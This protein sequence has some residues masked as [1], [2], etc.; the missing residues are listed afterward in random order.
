MSLFQYRALQADGTI[1]E[2]RLEAGGRQEAYRLLEGRGLKPVSLAEGTNGRTGDEPGLRLQWKS[3]RIPFRAL[4]GFT[5]QLS[6]LLAA[7]VPLSRSLRILSK[8][9]STPT[10]AE[11]WKEIH[12]LVIDGT[13]LADAMAQSPET[14]PRVYTA[15]VHAGETG[16]FLDVVLGQI[17]DFQT[18]EKE[19]R[20]K[21]IS[22]LIYPAVLLVL[23]LSVL[24]FLL[25]FFIPRFQTIFAGFGAAL[26][27]LT[28][29][30]VAASA[31]ATKYGPFLAAGLVCLFILARKWLQTDQG[32]RTW[33]R[34][35]LRVP[36]VGPL[37]ARFAMTRFCRMLGTLVGSGVPL[38]NALRVARESIGNQ[39]LVD[40][41]TD[42]I[43]RVKQ[44]EALASSLSDCPQ[45][46]PG[47]VLEMISVAEE[48]GR[49]DRELVRVATV[50]DG[51]L[52]RQL[53]TAVAL[54]EPLMLFLM[55][56]FIGTIFVGMVIPIF[57][58]QQYIK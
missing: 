10:A 36:V 49:L 20:S 6:S 31:L 38:I 22:A 54:A 35:I 4:E 27:T 44:G 41:V 40:A 24:T 34:M 2:G 9:A 7:G 46:F 55:A 43:E 57:T 18:R 25:V 8:E 45:L 16:G 30:I 52:D 56:G 39:T 26:P 37:N 5:R 14:F 3:R 42:S 15:M 51:D 47:S 11:K 13:S 50:T 33:Q 23:A 28:R 53:K 58:I 12:D 32:R 17:A 19:L 29:L 21:V 48:T 1:A